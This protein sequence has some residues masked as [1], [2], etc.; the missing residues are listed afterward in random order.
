LKKSDFLKAL[1]EIKIDQT[2][3]C[4][5][6]VSLID[7]GIF[8]DLKIDEINN[9]VFNSLKK[10]THKNCT[11]STLTPFYEYADNKKAFDI[12]RSL[13][14][15]AIGDFARF[16]Y[17][18]EKS[19]RSY[20]PLFNISSIGPLA[21]KITLSSTPEDFGQNSPWEN[22][23]NINSD[24]IFIGCDI[25]RCTF[26]RFIE[27]HFKVPYLIKKVF[28]TKIKS[29]GRTL[30]SKSFSTLRNLNL[31]VKYNT[32]KFQNVLIKKKVLR[33]N[34]H[35]KF[36]I[37]A[38]DMKSAFNVGI[39]QLKKDKYFFVNKKKLLN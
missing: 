28:H 25:S 1:S 13:P 31:N 4:L 5:V 36:N 33:I 20:N 9:F 24:M 22:L 2:K 29:K 8:K 7:L 34:S 10:F 23:Y 37:M 30:F 3:S 26:I 11:I 32:K 6:H 35:P 12:M 17:L 18:K 39:Q 15:K 21:K 14:S 19:L 38:V 27:H 16:V